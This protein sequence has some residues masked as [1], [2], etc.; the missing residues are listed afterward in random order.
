MQDVGRWMV[1]SAYLFSYQC[2]RVPAFA[3]YLKVNV[4]GVAVIIVLLPVYNK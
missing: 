4:A 2:F 3:I 1:V